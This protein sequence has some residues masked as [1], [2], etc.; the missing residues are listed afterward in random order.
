MSW[1]LMWEPTDNPGT[2]LIQVWVEDKY[3]L[4][5]NVA[6]L[7]VNMVDRAPNTPSA[8]SGPTYGY[9]NV[10]Y[11]YSTSTSDSDGDNV[12]YQFEFTGP[13][14]NVSFTTGWYA[15]GQT[16][17][18]TVM[19]ETTD[20]PGTYYVRARAK[21]VYGAWSG[22]SPY[23]TVTIVNRAPN[24]PSTPSGP[25]A[26]YTGTSY[27]YST[28]TTDPDGDNVCYQFDWGDGSTTT[29][30]FY[31]SGSTVYASHTWS[32]SGTY[33]VK[34]RAQDSYGA[35]SGWS[36]SLTV[37][38]STS[39]SGGGGGG[40][41]TLFS[42]NGTGY[43]EEAL[44]DIHASQDV[45]VDYKLKYLEPAGR[46]CMFSLR[47][48]DNYTSHIDYVKL[49]AVDAE[50]NWHE[51]RLILALH[52]ELGPVTAQL[53]SDDDVR[54]NLEPTQRVELLFTLPNNIDNIQYFIFELNGYNVKA[55][56][57]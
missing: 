30:S 27:S 12:C 50:G 19:W 15:S 9:R 43:A 55:L 16:G 22:W 48:L 38:I 35:W 11:T 28:S 14:T 17:S 31:S 23:L 42:W 47:E 3:G 20:P 54:I 57:T 6:S 41:P 10:W 2:Y 33:Y 36:S 53:S 51:C 24:T 8:P 1:N 32:S 29:T 18:L 52:N 56:L 4:S 34:V 49:Y 25:T 21:D 40:C 39:S 7:S 46:L 5:S 37:T 44:L 13:N 45:T 26:G